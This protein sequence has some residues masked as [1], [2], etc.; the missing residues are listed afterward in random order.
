QALD[1]CPKGSVVRARVLSTRGYVRT[2]LGDFANGRADAEAAVEMAA[3]FSDLSAAGR[4][5]SALHRILS[6]SGK[7]EAAQTAADAACAG[8]HMGG[9]TL[10]LTQRDLVHALLRLQEGELD[11]CY[12]SAARGLARLPENEL[13]CTAYLLGLQSLAL[14][15]RGD[16]DGAWPPAR[17]S[18]E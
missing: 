3:V 5:H 6:Q 12:A 14:F 7:H 18:M 13:W 1:R 10:A 15:L 8:L 17:R 16:F 9:D 4:A 11:E 2:L